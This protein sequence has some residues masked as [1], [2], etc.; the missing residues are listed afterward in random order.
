MSSRRNTIDR[1]YATK[2]EGHFPI[3]LVSMPFARLA[4]SPQL[5]LLKAI[6]DREG[7]PAET[8]HFALD[9]AREVGVN[10]YEALAEH[11]GILLGEWLFAGAAFDAKVPDGNEDFLQDFNAEIQIL[12]DDIERSRNWL[13]QIRTRLA[14]AFIERISKAVDWLQS[15]TFHFDVP[16][17]HGVVCFGAIPQKQSSGACHHSWGCEFRWPNG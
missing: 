1:G 11:R 12:L 6:A 10:E 17:K 15:R 14:P 2:L 8:F 13:A 9:F 16:A 5:G 7:F 3:A 4:P